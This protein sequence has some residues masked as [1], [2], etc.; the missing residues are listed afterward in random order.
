[1][2]RELKE[3]WRRV[4]YRCEHLEQ[5]EQNTQQSGMLRDIKLELGA[6]SCWQEFVLQSSE[7]TGQELSTVGIVHVLVSTAYGRSSQLFEMA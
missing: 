7:P 2:E 4:S 1:M 6:L 3:W 5:G